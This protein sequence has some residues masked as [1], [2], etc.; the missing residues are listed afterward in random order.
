MSD[1]K[2]ETLDW[3]KSIALAI[4]IA[5]IIRTFIFNT[6]YVKGQSMEPTLS[7]GDRLFTNRIVYVVSEPKRNDIVILNAP[8]D[9][10]K[11]Y[12]KRVIAIEG[13]TIVIK[14]GKVYLNNK[15]LTEKYLHEDAY[16]YQDLELIVPEGEVFV[17]GD[18]R[19]KGASKD[20]RYFGTIPIKLIIGKANFRYYPFDSRFGTLK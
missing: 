15:E 12:I 10:S 1:L 11:D 3:I 13:D 18:N 5:L 6:T 20:G 8:D 14:D 7:E 16:T 2:S 9:P 17:L 19:S 4:I